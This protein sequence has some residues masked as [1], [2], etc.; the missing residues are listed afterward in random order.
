MN[1]NFHR[2][3]CL[4]VLIVSATSNAKAQE[5]RVDII[6][7]PESLRVGD[8]LKLNFEIMH[9]E[10]IQLQ[11]PD[12][13]ISLLPIEVGEPMISRDKND[14]GI[15]T[16]RLE[17]EAFLFDTGMVIIPSQKIVYWHE[18]DSSKRKAIYTD[19]LRIYVKSVLTADAQEIRDIKEPVEIPQPFGHWK[20][21]FGILI[22]IALIA[23]AYYLWRKRINKPITLFKKPIVIKPAHEIALK[24]L[25]K[26]ERE[27]LVEKDNISP[28]YTELSKI[29]REYIENRYFLKA[30]EMTTTEVLDAIEEGLLFDS[31]GDT[32]KSVLTESDLV[33]F[34]RFKPEISVG[35]NLLDDTVAL[36]EK[37]KVVPIEIN[38]GSVLMTAQVKEE[39][40]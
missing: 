39:E 31:I 26:L 8:L 6:A 5:I 7:E 28:Y 25:F 24:A 9:E 10:E 27:N 23:V 18:S 14:D 13:R 15:L 29:L 2:I 34:A 3:I 19:S 4:L 21:V 33:K 17:F 37:T 22:A 30:L 38:S 35:K 20:L 16:E 32:V 1:M 40:V 36:V 11:L 12:L